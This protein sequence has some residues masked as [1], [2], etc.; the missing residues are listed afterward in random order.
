[1][2]NL[3]AYFNV[4]QIILLL[5]SST[6]ISQETIILQP[7]PAE[8]KDAMV[9]TLNPYQNWGD[10]E[11]LFVA[12]WTY[13]GDFGITRIVFNFDLS[14]IPDSS[15]I[16]NAYLSL[17]YNPT[18]GHEGHG[19]SNESYLSRI[20][21]PWEENT[22]NWNNQPDITIQNQV[23]LPSSTSPDQD[24]I[25][26]DVTSLVIDMIN[27]EENSHGFMLQLLNE[28][29]YRS[30]IF[31]SSDHPIENLHPKLEITLQCDSPIAQF[32]Y[33]LNNNFVQ[34]IDNSINATSWFWDFGDGYSSNLQNPAHIFV[35]NE[36]YE[37]CLTASNSC[38]SDVSCDT[39]RLI[40]SS[41][42]SAYQE[43]RLK[44]YPNPVKG[45]INISLIDIRN[46]KISVELINNTGKLLLN[47]EYILDNNNQNIKLNLTEFSSGIYIL[48]LT[49]NNFSKTQKI[50][51][52]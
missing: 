18:C 3:I 29:V 21:S 46:D 30:L 5:V 9:R 50:Y 13:N 8:G 37:V 23:L 12:A 32:G 14:I 49:S 48:R 7:G 35:G 28:D 36:V 25:N 34:F 19:G 17:Y 51:I 42:S 24:Y 31:A 38:G 41:T 39:L 11:D 26:I 33:T 40:I 45:M 20:T 15:E 44:I 52:Q 6:L 47:Q 22:V 27:N 4:F 10:N 43:E 1:M 16:E 2:K